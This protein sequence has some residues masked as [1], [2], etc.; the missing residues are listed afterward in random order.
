MIN[1]DK[2]LACLLGASIKDA[3]GSPTETRNTRQIKEKFG[4]FVNDFVDSPEDVFSAG[5]PKGS[6]TDDF[7]LAIKA[8]YSV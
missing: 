1:Y 4:G 3:M 7:S 2:I 8:K 6:V 5:C